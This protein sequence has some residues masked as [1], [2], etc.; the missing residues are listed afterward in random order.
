MYNRGDIV[1]VNFNPV[2]GHEQGD[3]R[4]ALVMNEVPL[5]GGINIVLPITTKNKTYPFEVVL[6]GR[7]KTQGVV[8]CFQV[9]TV[10]LASRGAK[11]VETLPSDLLEQC[12]DYVHRLTSAV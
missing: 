5:P 2:K 9:R 8:L 12:A 3:Y 1:L 7:T 6:D 11:V 4:P 10:D